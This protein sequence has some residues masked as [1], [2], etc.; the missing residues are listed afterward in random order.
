MCELNVA[1]LAGWSQQLPNAILIVVQRQC[2]AFML[3]LERVLAPGRI[4]HIIATD[5]NADHLGVVG[6]T[7]SSMLSGWTGA[8][9]PVKTQQALHKGEV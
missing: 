8:E 2:F 5:I 6:A 3:A 1:S 4:N 7:D 9:A